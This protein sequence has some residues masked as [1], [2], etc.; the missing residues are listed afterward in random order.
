MQSFTASIAGT[1]LLSSASIDNIAN[2]DGVDTWV[3]VS[4]VANVATAG[5]YAVDFTFTGEG[6][7]AVDVVVDRVFVVA[8]DVLAPEPASLALLAVPLLG[9]AVLQRGRGAASRG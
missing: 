6:D 5:S 1:P 4:G 3:N 2:T 8:G 9:L 7:P